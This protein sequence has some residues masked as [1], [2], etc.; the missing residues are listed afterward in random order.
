MKIR[1]SE[2][3]GCVCEMMRKQDVK[4]DMTYIVDL[5]KIDGDGAFACP[6]CGSMISPDDE[7][8]ENY[9]ILNTKV[10]DDNLEELV[11]ICTKCK[12]TIKLVGFLA[13]Q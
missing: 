9:Q 6:K 13:Q 7:S 12:A 2:T 10:K 11:L 4:K 1:L 3:E 8:D 5:T